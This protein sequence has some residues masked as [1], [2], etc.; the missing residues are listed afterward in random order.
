VAIDLELV[1]C[2]LEVQRKNSAILSVGEFLDDAIGALLSLTFYYKSLYDMGDSDLVDLGRH[3]QILIGGLRNSYLDLLGVRVDRQFDTVL[4]RPAV[5]RD[6]GIIV[7]DLVANAAEHAVARR[8]SRICVELRDTRAGLICRV[9]G[10][11]CGPDDTTLG[12][13]AGGG[14]AK[15]VAA[16]LG[17]FLDTASSPQGATFTVGVPWSDEP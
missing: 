3:L 11:G 8:G 1:A 4:V 5:A 7:V 9:T 15:E 2:A 10:D 14:V 17:G 12:R 6:L 13:E 16:R